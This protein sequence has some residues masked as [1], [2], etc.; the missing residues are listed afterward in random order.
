MLFRH[1]PPPASTRPSLCLVG[2]FTYPTNLSTSSYFDALD[3]MTLH[4]ALFSHSIMYSALR[5]P[6]EHFEEGSMTDRGVLGR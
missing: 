5:T 2:P 6:Q 4:A 3:T 1:V